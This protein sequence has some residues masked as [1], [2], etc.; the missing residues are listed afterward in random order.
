MTNNDT[1]IPVT[2]NERKATIDRRTFLGAAGA[3]AVATTLAGCL[4]D[5]DDLIRVGHIGPLQQDMGAGSENSAQLAVDQLNEEDGIMDREVE[6]VSA[7]S[8]GDPGEALT[9][10]EEMVEQDGV[11]V[12]IGTFVTEVMQGITDYVADVDVPF[13]ITG[14]ADPVTVTDT[15]AEDYDR[16][17]NIFRSGPINSDLQAEGMVDYAEFLADEYGWT[18]FA[19]IAD[20][21]AWTEPFS[22]N[23]PG[24][25][26]DV[27]LD[28]VHEDRLAPGTDDWAPV[29]SDIDDADADAVFRFFAHN[30]GTGM[31]VNW[32][33]NEY[34]FAIEGIH[35]PG[36][37]P[38][39]WDDSE[40]A[41][42][43]ET[44]S[45][46][47]AAGAADIT[48]ETGPFVDA[49]AEE[50]GDDRPSLPMYMGFNTYD[51]V[52][53]YKDAVE[54]AGT[55]DYQADI[56]TIVDELLETDHEGAAGEI[57][58]YGPDEDYP[59]DVRETTDDDGV[60]TNFPVTQW[61]DDGE[62][63]CVYPEH[64]ASADHITPEWL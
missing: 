14:S 4:G 59:H 29:N 6:L 27:G 23:L 3:G 32:R 54:R 10:T 35:V 42:L 48:S 64:L 7:D 39:F 1:G 13:L 45:Q 20:D 25:L 44:T 33:E 15:V 22:D 26:E 43:Y 8:V 34:E 12:I 51:A 62:F 9:A 55:V 61:Q 50:Y 19:H 37:S 49:Y 57:E 2:R 63:E 16:F 11:D 18:Q 46:S 56:D 38:E 28:V 21:A 31:L 17:K 40:G 58:F 53:V 5:E 24:Y 52:F 60:I 47:G 41:A 30:V 36:M